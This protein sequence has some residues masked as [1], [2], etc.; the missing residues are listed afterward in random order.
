MSFIKMLGLQGILSLGLLITPSVQAASSFSAKLLDW[1][2]KQVPAG[3]QCQKFGGKQPATPRIEVSGLPATTNLILLEYSDRSYQPMNHGG[4]GRMA[5]AIH[6]PGKNLI[7]PSVLGHRFSLPSGFMIVEPHRNPK[8]D[9]AGAY[10][11]PC[12]GGKGHD[13]YVTVTA[14]HFDGNQATSLAKTVIE[15]GKY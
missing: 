3:Q 13:Y 4:H 12:S 15:L 10:M 8:W 9:Q 6:Q 14:L 1:D 7:I 11:P 5:F 2:G